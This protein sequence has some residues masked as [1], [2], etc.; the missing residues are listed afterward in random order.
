MRIIAGKYKGRKL[1]YPKSKALL[2]PTKDM[3]KEALFS[4]LGAK[5][6]NAKFLDLCA[7]VGSIGFEALS[8]GAQ[9]V[10]FIDTNPE[11]I[12]TNAKELGCLAEVEIYKND[13]TR[14]IEILAK[15]GEKFDII[16]L[17][18]PYKTDLAEVS[19]NK[20][21]RFDILNPQ[22]LIVLET[23]RDKQIVSEFQQ[24]KERIYGQTKILI[25]EHTC[26]PS[27]TK[28]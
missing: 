22:G 1:D 9:K 16:Y 21:S 8:R 10:C 23:A 2:R 20:L 18:P 25:M 4:I 14:A 24:V 11:Y 26:P 28:K 5:I 3:V 12:F 13:C 17:D 19:L 27:P 7:G 6:Q 15:R